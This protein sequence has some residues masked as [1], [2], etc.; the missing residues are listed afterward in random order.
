M[1]KISLTDFV[2]IVSS[3]GIPKVNKVLAIKKRAA[4]HPATDYYKGLRSHI[5]EV[6]RSSLPK[7]QI[8]QGASKT[9]DPKKVANY[10]EISDAYHSWWGKKDIS[11]F[12]PTSGVFER[13]G[14]TV[15]VNPELGLI[16]DGTRY[17]V[18]LYFKADKL[19]KN[20]ADMIT[21]LMYHCI[22]KPSKNT[23]MSILDIRNKKLFTETATIDLSA[24]LSAELA[25]IADLL[26]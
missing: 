17:L 26:A 5:I 19:T 9:N 22:K 12:E 25:Y 16:I 24:A 21:F 2:D 1:N 14:I 3:S 6:H 4:Y 8:K 7:A 15:N 23:V 11:W 20:R 18:K 10:V 13:H